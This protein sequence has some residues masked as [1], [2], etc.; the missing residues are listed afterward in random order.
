M[1]SK[2]NC[3][4]SSKTKA[5]TQAS[6]NSYY[7]KIQCYQIN[8]VFKKQIYIKFLKLDKK[9][10]AITFFAVKLTFDNFSFSNRILQKNKKIDCT[11]FTWFAVFLWRTNVK[12]NV[13][14]S[15]IEFSFVHVKRLKRISFYTRY[16]LR[17]GR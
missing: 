16:F 7:S 6:V 15:A 2:R 17:N 1:N 14:R 9:T 11:N 13:V 8:I 12:N 5:R 4:L 3:L 10:L